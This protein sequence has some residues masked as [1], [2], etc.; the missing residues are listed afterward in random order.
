MW[1]KW[2]DGGAPVQVTL[3]GSAS[4]QESFDGRDLYF[5]KGDLKPG[6][7]RQPLAGGPEEEIVPQ[8]SMNMWGNWRVTRSAF[9]S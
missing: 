9:L 6:L 7:W 5:S 2:I 1:K 3:N 8:L 4:A